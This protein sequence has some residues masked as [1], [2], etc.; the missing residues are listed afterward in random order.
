M[1]EK[2]RLYSIVVCKLEGKSPFERPRYLWDCN[3]RRYLR[4][5]NIY[6]E[7]WLDLAQGGI[8]RRI[9][10]NAAMNL[11]IIY[12]LGIYFVNSY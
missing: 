11:R 2:K 7:K 10:V 1:E 6:G 5:T 9:F 3:I 8:Q 4:V 12:D